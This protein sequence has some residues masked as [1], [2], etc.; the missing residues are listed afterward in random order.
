MTDQPST[1]TI[2]QEAVERYQQFQEHFPDIESME[3]VEEAAKDAKN[4]STE[5]EHASVDLIARQVIVAA[6]KQESSEREIQERFLGWKTQEEDP[7]AL[8]W[9]SQS[10]LGSEVDFTRAREGQ[11][12]NAARKNGCRTPPLQICEGPFSK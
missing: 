7:A 9:L 1:D 3:R 4:S 12:I 11:V 2:V 5:P 10:D 6:G 8:R